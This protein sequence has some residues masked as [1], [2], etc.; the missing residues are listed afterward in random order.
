M[1]DWTLV[2]ETIY[3]LNFITIIILICFR[4]NNPTT[5]MAWVMAFILLP[6]VGGILY[7]VFGVG[8]HSYS[9]RK[10]R[11]KLEM[12]EEY[13]LST[14]KEL[15]KE[16]ENA[17]YSD[18]INYFLN[19]ASVYTQNNSVEIFTKATA[20][21]ESLLKDIESA[22]ES[23]NVLYFII[24][25]D[26]IGN[27]IVDALLKKAKEGVKVKLMYDGLGSLLTPK[28]I[29]DKLRAEPNCEVAE[30]FPVR[31]FSASKINHR[32]HRKI[33]V[34]DNEIAYVGGMNIG[35]EYMGKNK[36]K[37]L[38]WRDT[39]LKIIGE[40]VEY[41]NGYFA[42]DWQ[43]STGKE[44]EVKPYSGKVQDEQVGMQVV[45]SGPDTKHEEIKN[46]MLKMIY[47]AK[48]YIYIQTPYFVPDQAFLTA[49]CIAAQSGIDVRVMIPGVPDKKYVYH[50]TM[51]YMDEL[52][53]HGIKVFLY[54]GFI[55][56]KTITVDD[57][58]LTVGTTNID[59]RSFKLLFEINSFM[60]S[61]KTATLHREIFEDD[62]EIC[63]MLTMEEYK[64]RGIIRIIKEGFFRL[65]SPIM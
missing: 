16:Y 63:S 14:Q 5:T 50:T 45:A 57:K 64:K 56:S 60:Y 17:A 30:F 61:E 55:H 38:P 18:M 33:V 62:E 35:D 51:S 26:T 44:V 22:T 12:R 29:F 24:R 46:G 13:I 59:I 52:L 53:E 21:Y 54:P 32:N 4:K 3:V 34:I 47:N 28:R 41:I 39:H 1:I 6:V 42:L 11:Q 40:A 36:R 8:V 7:V 65:F 31:V 23:I 19:C 9:M 20:K 37:N 10:Y 43:F 27:R 48:K 2:I 58:I 15:L 49:L 25:N